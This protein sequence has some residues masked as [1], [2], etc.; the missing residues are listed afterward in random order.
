MFVFRF[1]QVGRRA[2]LCSCQFAFCFF[3]LRV[4]F[5]QLAFVVVRFQNVQGPSVTFQTEFRAL[6]SLFGRTNL[7]RL[8]ESFLHQFSG[9][10]QRFGGLLKFDFGQSDSALQVVQFN[11]IVAIPIFFQIE[12]S[13]REFQLR[14]CD[15]AVTRVSRNLN[16]IVLR[17]VDA[18]Q[19]HQQEQV[20]K[21]SARLLR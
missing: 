20:S 8:A 17:R 11:Q 21:E 4:E 16:V 18:A 6:H 7:F 19:Q 14:I 10:L 9:V 5:R 15:L 3:G 13:Q 2:G 12:I 1:F